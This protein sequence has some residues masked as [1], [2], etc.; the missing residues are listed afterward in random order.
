MFADNSET[1]RP[2]LTT[3]RWKNMQIRQYNQPVELLW[4]DFYQTIT[5]C[6]VV[7]DKVPS[8]DMDVTL[9]ISWWPKQNSLEQ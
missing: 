3:N 9:R 6:N 5:C 7:I 4:R 2:A 8:I 1:I